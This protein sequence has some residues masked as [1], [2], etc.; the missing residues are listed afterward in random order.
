MLLRA[1]CGLALAAGLAAPAGGAAVPLAARQRAARG[2]G[3]LSGAPLE[4]LRPRPQLADGGG[5]ARAVA[6]S[7]RG[8]AAV[9]AAIAP[10][11]TSLLPPLATIAVSL[12]AKQVIIALLAGLWAGACLLHANPVVALLRSVDTYALEAL[13]DP[14][15]AGILI[16]TLLLGGAIGLIQKTGGSLGLARAFGPLARTRRRAAGTTFG[17]SSL[18]FFDDYSS[19]LITG[20]SLRKPAARAGL[21]LEKFAMIVHTMG[22]CV[23]SLSP[24]SSWT[25][26]QLGYVAGAVAAA[27]LDMDGFSMML[28]TLPYRLLPLIFIGLVAVSAFSGRDFGAIADA[29]AAAAARGPAGAAAGAA[30]VDAPPAAE[31]GGPLDPKPGTPLRPLNALLPFGAIIVSAFLGMLVDGATRLGPAARGAG[32]F[33]MLAACDSVR[34]LI[35]ASLAGTGTALALALGQRILNV[36]E[37]LAAWMEGMKDVLEPCVI[38]TLAWALGAVIADVKAAEFLAGLLKGGLPKPALPPLLVLLCY[39]MSYA[40]GS[41]A[42]ARAPAGH[43]ARARRI[44]SPASCA[45]RHAPPSGAGTMGVIFPLA[46]PLA[47]SLSGGDLGFVKNCFGAILGSSLWGNICSPIADTTI[48]TVLA[49]KCPLPAHV[50]AITQ[51]A[52]L[53]GAIALAANVLLSLGVVGP[54]GALLTGLAMVGVSATRFRPEPA[55]KGV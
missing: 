1:L 35:W 53:A 54:G 34:A 16:F 33:G 43:R 5:G 24:V 8:G 12:V 52:S 4:R 31:E 44:R 46:A 27:G 36:Q 21:S 15:H 48:M 26:L 10:H 45:P 18:I 19:V 7:L 25:G 39:A 30:A 3:A 11:W 42:G 6:M 9:A 51:Y 41:A 23:A 38:L 47:A 22:T 28:A 55:A 2:L 49:T 40:T 20:N 50:S 32:V 14:D 13:A 17:L 37:A 29:E